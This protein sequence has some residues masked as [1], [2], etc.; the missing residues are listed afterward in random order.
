[1]KNP[2]VPPSPYHNMCHFHSPVVS[3][4]NEIMRNVIEARCK[5][6]RDK[7]E[8]NFEGYLIEEGNEKC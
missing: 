1:M 6:T 8:E 3:L 5:E 7:D 4:M 2:P